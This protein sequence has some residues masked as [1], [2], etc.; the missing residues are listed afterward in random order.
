M[1]GRKALP[2]GTLALLLIL[3]LATVGVGYG[4]WAEILKIDGTVTTGNVDV[5]LSIQEVDQGDFPEFNQNDV[6]DDNEEELYG[7]DVADCKV[8][9]L[10]ENNRLRITITEGYPSFWCW[11]EFD[12]HGLGSIP[13]LVDQPVVIKA[14]PQTEVSTRFLWCYHWPFIPPPPPP[15]DPHPQLHRSDRVF[16]ALGFHVE[17]EAQQSTTYNFEYAICAH[18][19]NEEPLP[20]CTAP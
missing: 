11:V 16:C 1:F 17:Q 14:P 6:W 7:K 18:Q 12:V 4:L 19:F 13:V 8:E 5:E 15:I 20:D 9:L 10:E 2:L 3:A